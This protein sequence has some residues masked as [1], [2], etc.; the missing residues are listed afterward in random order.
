M[1]NKETKQHNK[2]DWK[3]LCLELI[4]VFLGVT[5]GFILNNWSTNN[6]NEQLE[7]KYLNS[8]LEDIKND[9]VELQKSIK[10]DSI[11]LSQAKPIVNELNE[12][13]RINPDS[14]VRIIGLM[15]TLSQLDTR[16]TTYIDIVNSGNFNLIQ[17]Y[18]L[19][20]KIID[21]YADKESLKFFD[22]FF[23]DFFNTFS[24]PIIIKEFDLIHLQFVN[25][26]IIDETFFQNTFINH[27]SLIQQRKGSYDSLLVKGYELQKQ[28]ENNLLKQS[29]HQD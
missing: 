23:S 9:I 13:E 27:T 20:T 8:F 18:E 24:L 25:P 1:S 10:I 16:K 17:D 14:S 28:L 5:A 6:T 22:D 7:R 2:T 19:K 4:V 12:T 3:A 21:Y 15:S 11:W 26:H 29:N